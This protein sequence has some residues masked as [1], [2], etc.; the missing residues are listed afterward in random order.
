MTRAALAVR[1]AAWLLCLP[2]AAPVLAQLELPTLLGDHMVVQRRDTVVLWGTAAAGAEVAALADWPAAERV[3]AR[4]DGGGRFVLRLGT[5]DAGG[6]YRVTIRSGDAT[7]TLSDVLVGE[8]WVCSGQSNMEWEMRKVASPEVIAQA[9]HP[10]LRL[11]TVENTTASAPREHCNGEWRA[12][13]PAAAR[14]FSA[15]ALFFGRALEE[16]LDVPIG[17]IASDWGGT[18]AEAWT[19]AVGL[20]DLT[21]FAPAIA[22][23][24]RE[25]GD[26]DEAVRR[27]EKALGAWRE[28]FDAR[29]AGLREGWHGAD[30]DDAS[31]DTLEVPGAWTG[32]LGSF[33]GVV[34]HRRVVE[35]PREWQARAATLA[36]GPID[37]DDATWVNGVRVGGTESHL[38]VR[39]YALPAGTLRE[40]RNVV[41]V[42]VYD[43][44]GAGGFHGA[45]GDLELV[46][47]GL[48]AVPLAGAWRI[49]RG[50]RHA[51][52][53][54][55][56]RA[57]GELSPGTPTALFNGM[58]APLRNVAMR[59]VIW[60]QGE[61]NRERAQ[62]YEKLFPALIDDWR[63]QWGRGDFPFYFV[64]I[65][66]F[67]YGNDTGQ[68][69]L[70]RD[71]QR[72]TLRVPN[73]GMAV[74]LDIGNPGDIH[75][76]N[77]HDVGARLARLALHHTYGH[78]VVP[79]GPLY[80][81]FAID[82]AS[83]RI[84]FDHVA[85][86]LRAR[87][88]KALTCFTIAG[89]DRAFVPA[90]AV[91][92]GDSVVVSSA[93]VPKPVAV[94]FAWGAADEPNLCNA[95]GLPASS[96]RTDEW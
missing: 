42:R 54:A 65:A 70:L 58:I 9:N 16:A 94:R 13:T 38:A 75:P 6:P 63:A 56:P 60:Y 73:T 62:Q 47:D 79:C 77:K 28:A 71:A 59:G 51:D 66:P 64:Q 76:R 88:G 69:A 33:D 25:S 80:R 15:T 83:V 4:A 39:R 7:R 52:L 49:A 86:G 48:A 1:V 18:P 78:D 3:T 10:R 55:R 44:G 92:D 41:A 14:D 45:A 11:F 90:D 29:D 43:S 82:G 19:S 26:P 53:P 87:D 50:A 22:R 40:G 37:D 61:S 46:A 57:P 68:A 8:V 85:G 91:V 20:R 21:E 36:L 2:C 89:E 95:E 81:S 35:L 5:P 67:R 34:W 32:E 30:H 31:W 84:A 17:L 93:A 27:H 12:C 72:K 24:L 96:F 74:T 23:L